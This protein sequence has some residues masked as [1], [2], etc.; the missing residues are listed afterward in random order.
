MKDAI[1]EKNLPV[2][3]DDVRPIEHI[4]P[5]LCWRRTLSYGQHLML[6]HWTLAEGMVSPVHRHPHEMIS[7]VVEGQLS[8]KLGDQTYLLGPG[9]SLLVPSNVEHGAT[10]LKPSI[11]LDVF[12][13]PRDEYR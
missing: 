8:Y 2:S 7:Y 11:L 5:G 13:P 10:A 3:V 1:A 9:D 6:V 12:S 4:K